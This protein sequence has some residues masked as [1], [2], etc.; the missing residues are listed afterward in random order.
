MFKLLKRRIGQALAILIPGSVILTIVTHYG[1]HPYTLEAPRR[2]DIQDG[3]L[4]ERHGI[5]LHGK[6]VKNVTN[7]VKSRPNSNG[8][9]NAT[10]QHLKSATRDRFQWKPKWQHNL[11]N[12]SDNRYNLHGKQKLFLAAAFRVRIY[13]EDKAKWTIR[14]LKQWFHYMFWAGV[15]HIFLCDHFQVESEILRDQLQRYIKLNL[16]T[17]IPWNVGPHTLKNQVQCYQKII[18][19][20]GKFTTWQ[21]AVDMDE[22]PYVHNDTNEGFLVRY[23]Q[24]FDE[25]TAEV[26][27]PNFVLLGQGNRTKNMTIERIDRIES[28]TKK[29]SDLDKPIYRPEKVTANMHH[30]T[31]KSGRKV[32]VDGAKLKMLHYWGGRLQKWGPDTPDII[33]KTV[34][35]TEVREKLAPIIRQSLLDF[36]EFDS[37]SNSTG[38]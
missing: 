9:G 21:I 28:L 25:N 18:D 20:Y 4:N 13:K 11:S 7:K 32:D 33:K 14:E 34:P 37:F 30:N 8:L 10:Q 19:E 5:Y 35:F 2:Q 3:I 15:E 36:G 29:S 24:Q 22:F 12:S 27:M 23:L 26:S 17:Y 38:P 1:L 16:L 31:I 6:N